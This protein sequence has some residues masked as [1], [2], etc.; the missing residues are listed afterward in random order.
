MAV[1]NLANPATITLRHFSGSLTDATNVS[2]TNNSTSQTWLVKSCILSNNDNQYNGD[3]Q[4]RV[5]FSPSSVFGV[6]LCRYVWIPYGT[7]LTII[8]ESL[9]IYLD[10][11]H[12]L[13]IWNE[14][15]IN[16]DY[17]VSIATIAE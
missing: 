13:V 17:N 15:G 16:M 4:A 6:D 9:P 11:G 8:N 10:Y 1:Q 12:K 7:N 5:S 2:I 14:Q 3:V